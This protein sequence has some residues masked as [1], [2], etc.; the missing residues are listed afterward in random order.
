[1]HIGFDGHNERCD[2]ESKCESTTRQRMDVSTPV[3]VVP[4]VQVGSA[5]IDCEEPK[6][7]GYA[8]RPCKRVCEFIIK[9]KIN[10]EIPICYDIRTDIGDSFVDCL[11]T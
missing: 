8:E 7:C 3:R 1:M 6:I 5:R 4:V 11:I 9:Q 10:I 2:K